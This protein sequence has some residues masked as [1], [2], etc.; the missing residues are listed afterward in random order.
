MVVK[1]DFY[2]NIKKYLSELQ[3]TNIR[4]LEDIINF[5]YDNDGRKEGIRTEKITLRAAGPII[6]AIQLS[7]LGR[8][9]F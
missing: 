6:A 4:S 8:M 2:N 1:V 5:N 3:N 9:V 7:A